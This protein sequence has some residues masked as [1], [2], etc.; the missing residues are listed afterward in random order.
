[1]ITKPTNIAVSPQAHVPGK[2]ITLDAHRKAFRVQP[3]FPTDALVKLH[4][5]TNPWRYQGMGWHF[6]E[7]VLRPAFTKKDTWTVGELLQMGIP[8]S[9]GPD[10]G[11]EHLRWLFTWGGSYVEIAG[12]LYTPPPEGQVIPKRPSKR[13]KAVAKA[14]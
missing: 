8:H 6:Y 2:P 3:D 13:I 7:L 9:I 14:V 1:M 4:S 5:W 10:E 12:S 11:M